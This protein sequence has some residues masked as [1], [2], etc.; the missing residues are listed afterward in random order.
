MS[1]DPG[2][3]SESP[4]S[5]TVGRSG[6][7]AQ[8]PLMERTLVI[9]AS[10]VIDS[11]ATA[12]LRDLLAHGVDVTVVVCSTADADATDRIA[13]VLDDIG[14]HDHRILGGVGARMTDLT[15]RVYRASSD[16]KDIPSPDSLASTDPGEVAA[17]IATVIALTGA[18][19][20]ILWDSPGTPAAD[21][22]I[23]E[24]TGATD[25]DV[26]ASSAA[27]RRAA[28]VMAVPVFVRGLDAGT[29]ERN[30]GDRH[31]SSV[32]IGSH[33]YRRDGDEPARAPLSWREQRIGWRIGGVLLAG[34]LGIATGALGTVTQAWTL[35]VGGFDF[36]LGLIGGLVVT[37]TLLTGLRLIFDTRAI[38]LA[39]AL[40]LL[41]II[42]VL[43][44]ESRG[45]SVLVPN[46]A[47]SYGWVYGPVV[48]A[49]VVVA[50][51]RIDRAR[52]RLPAPVDETPAQ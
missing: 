31:P 18:G 9:I 16:P 14:V 2:G 8:V 1:I 22:R 5:G 11:A 45:G 46:T 51:P 29:E 36:P 6:V 3:L 43:S 33:H 39:T 19:S 32:I 50:W 41:G 25:A 10:A 15:P 35:P 17:D 40:G 27:A 4:L 21:V 47:A 13:A 52:L 38:V 20:V 37:A 44:M 48:I 23:A 7:G 30:V 26:L 34:A 42:A 49:L 28:R 12:A 24:G